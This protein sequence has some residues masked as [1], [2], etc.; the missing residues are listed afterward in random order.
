MEVN[1]DTLHGDMLKIQQELSLLRRAILSEGGL[2]DWAE[3]ELK[4][5]R[6]ED[7]LEYTDLEAL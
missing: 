3:S 5:A 1:M 7:E 6:D 2:T 4:K